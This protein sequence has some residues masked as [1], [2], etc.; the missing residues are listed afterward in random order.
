MATRSL[1][2]KKKYHLQSFE[3]LPKELLQ[4]NMLHTPYH[5]EKEG[6]AKV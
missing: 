2:H 6:E 3:V 5:M 1:S 4:K